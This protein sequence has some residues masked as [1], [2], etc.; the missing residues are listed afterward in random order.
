MARAKKSSEVEPNPIGYDDGFLEGMKASLN[1]TKT[2]KKTDCVILSFKE[3]TK[4]C[5]MQ[6]WSA[7]VQREFGDA[8]VVAI[9]ESVAS[10]KVATIKDTIK[11]LEGVINELKSKS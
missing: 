2:P 3:G 8:I 5:S 4:P 9:P 1:I 10:V 11:Y 6:N 7:L